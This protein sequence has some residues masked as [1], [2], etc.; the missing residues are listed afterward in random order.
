MK[1][2]SILIITLIAGIF[3]PVSAE[4]LNYR[5]IQNGSEMIIVP[6]PSEASIQIQRPIYKIYSAPAKI[7]YYSSE[8]TLPKG[9]NKTRS[10]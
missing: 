5:I 7:P 10:V 9:K 1:K 4:T 2:I 8:R 6:S 3:L